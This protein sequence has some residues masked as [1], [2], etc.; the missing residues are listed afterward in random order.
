MDGFLTCVQKM[1]RSPEQ[2]IQISKQIETYRMEGGTF[3][4]DMAITDK[5][6]KMPSIF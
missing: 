2:R 5:T 1:V 6:I 4:F 3:G